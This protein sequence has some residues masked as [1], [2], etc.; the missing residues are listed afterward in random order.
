MMKKLFPLIVVLLSGCT[1]VDFDYP[2][3]QS[4]ALSDTSD[5][6]VARKVASLAEGRAETDSG[7]YVL[8]DGIDAAAARF[9][10]A[11][12]AERSIDVQYYLIKRDSVGQEFLYSLLQAADRGVRV[13]LMID[14]MFTSG[15]DADL[16]AL[17]SHP[18]FEIRIYNPFNRG[19]LGRNLGAVANFRRV[20]RRMHNKSFTIDNQVTIIGGRNIADEYFGAR[21]DSAFG[22]MDVIGVGPI[23][24]DVSNMFDTYWRHQAAVPVEGFIKPL[25]DSATVLNE[26]REHYVVHNAEMVNT[27]YAEAVIERAYELVES[28]TNGFSWAPYKLIY[29]TPDK[30]IKGKADPADLIIAPLRE[31]LVAVER[32]IVI[33]SPYFVPEKVFRDSLIAIQKSGIKVQIVTN[34]LAANNQKTVHGGYAPA[35]KPLLRAGVE[36]YE[37]RPDARIAGTEYV[38]SDGARSTL[39]TKSYVLDRREVFIG[40]FNFDPRSAYINTEM[41]VLIDDPLMGEEFVAR[42]EEALPRQVWSLS[43][44][45]KNRLVWQGMKDGEPVTY[46]KEPMTSFWAR[47]MA[48]FYRM[49][50]IRGQL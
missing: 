42:I 41:G 37:V 33:L 6:Y 22:D 40:S 2:R 48:G 32:E 3:T 13:R 25:K 9:R 46:S 24:Q 21:T 38:K 4:A 15:Y 31:S 26:L 23:V 16:M 7:F 5:T 8:V 19:L 1:S 27:P 44:D 35:R 30:G 47:L 10:L 50:P 36:L 34:S 18:N 17:N 45:Q 14:D 43:L 20:N 49:L 11:D 12:I 29:D 28:N 39:H